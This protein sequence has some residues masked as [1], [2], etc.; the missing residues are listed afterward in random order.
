M[1]ELGPRQFEE[2][3]AELFQDMGY[4]V[5]LTP[6]TRDG[7]RDVIAFFK[8]AAGTL[9][10]LIECKRFAPHR[11]VGVGIVRELY[12]VVEAER[13]SR[14]VVATTSFFTKDAE[15]FQERIKYR[16]SLADYQSLA[17]WC[18]TAGT[19]PK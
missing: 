2:L 10:T 1:R 13:A 14:G 19:A 11:P 8:D 4:E 5:R 17:D 12:G 16:L 6:R 18:R 3:V 7:G 9:L 15:A